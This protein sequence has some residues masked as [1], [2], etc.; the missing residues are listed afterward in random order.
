MSHLAALDG[1]I[2]TRTSLSLRKASLWKCAR[3]FRDRCRSVWQEMAPYAVLPDWL[4]P[5]PLPGPLS[6]THLRCH[7]GRFLLLELLS[8]ES[9]RQDHTD[10]L[11]SGGLRGRDRVGTPARLAECR[12]HSASAPQTSRPLV[13]SLC[14]TLPGP[15]GSDSPGSGTFW[16]RLAFSGPDGVCYPSVLSPPPRRVE[17]IGRGGCDS[18][19]TLMGGTTSG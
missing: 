7:V 19:I 13:C 4:L 14:P 1:Q 6:P 9:G 10:H 5:A 12:Q 17:P 15:R 11:G 8:Y 18:S 3:E 16:S 2:T